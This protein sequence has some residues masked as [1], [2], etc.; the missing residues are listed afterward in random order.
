M[1]KKSKIYDIRCQTI[2]IPEKCTKITDNKSHFCVEY[3]KKQKEYCVITGS[4]RECI[5]LNLECD[6]FEFNNTI[7][8]KTKKEY[9]GMYALDVF[10]QTELIKVKPKE[11]I[12][13]S[14]IC[15]G[16]GDLQV[17]D[18]WLCSRVGEMQMKQGIGEMT[19][20]MQMLQITG[21]EG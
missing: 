10:E 4:R 16:I 2:Y 1:R 18:R 21:G 13:F 19:S 17:K 3:G 20:G 8:N 6:I 5:E 15:L 11:I 12:K 7:I 14:K 9:I